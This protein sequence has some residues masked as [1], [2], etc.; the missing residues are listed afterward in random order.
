MIRKYQKFSPEVE[1]QNEL[2][3]KKTGM[4][5]KPKQFISGN[6]E[7]EGLFRRD[8]NLLR[9]LQEENRKTLKT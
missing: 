9:H 7:T 2:W 6:F 8:P 3:T 5:V 4:E 1:K